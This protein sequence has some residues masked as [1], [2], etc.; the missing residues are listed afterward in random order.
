MGVGVDRAALYQGEE[1]VAQVDEGS[2][3]QPPAQPEVEQSAVEGERFLDGADLE[4]DV[5]QTDRSRHARSVRHG[6]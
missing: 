6:L 2:T 5:V 1:L 3:P 4:R